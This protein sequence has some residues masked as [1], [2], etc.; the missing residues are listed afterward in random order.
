MIKF[1]CAGKNNAQIRTRRLDIN[2]HH[3][4]RLK[5]QHQSIAPSRD[6]LYTVDSGRTSILVETRKPEKSLSVAYNSQARYRVYALYGWSTRAVLKAVDHRGWPSHMAAILC[7]TARYVDVH[8][9]AHTHTFITYAT[10]NTHTRTR[11]L[12]RDHAYPWT[13]QEEGVVSATL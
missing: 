6:I 8:R 2:A 11:V 12:Q 1:Y 10:T 9:N 7:A 4:P 13:I 5:V 3:S